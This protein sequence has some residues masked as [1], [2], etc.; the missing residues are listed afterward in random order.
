MGD[1]ARTAKIGRRVAVIGTMAAGKSTLAAALAA[2]LGVPYLEL[3]SVRHGPHWTPTPK[4]ELRQIVAARL[5]GD[6]WT[7]DGNYSAVRDLIWGRAD[8]LIWLDY[9]VIVPLWRVT[10]RTLRRVVGRV[11]LWNGN[12]ET[13]RNSVFSR[14]N[15][16]LWIVRSHWRRRREYAA[17]VAQPEYAHLAVLRL[18]SPRATNRLLASLGVAGR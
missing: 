18:R 17:L 6:G 14:D 3:D 11:E 13:W 15:H 9:P 5:A 2:H 1:A 16:W 4:D 8:A 12:R 7:T 10:G